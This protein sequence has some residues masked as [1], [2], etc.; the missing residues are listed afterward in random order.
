MAMRVS[1][2]ENCRLT[3]KLPEV[4][5][6]RQIDLLHRVLGLLV[7]AHDGPHHAEKSLVVAP[8]DD[9][10]EVGFTRSDAGYDLFVR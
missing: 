5:I 6:R 3:R 4:G 9:L 8:H 2:V 10:E 7:L 1:H